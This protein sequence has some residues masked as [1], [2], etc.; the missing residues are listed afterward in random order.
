[1]KAKVLRFTEARK[2]SKVEAGP[3]LPSRPSAA[4]FVFLLF[5]AVPLSAAEL[6][7]VEVIAPTTNTVWAGQRVTFAVELLVQGQFAGSPHFDVPDVPGAIILKPSERP[8]LGTREIEGE[9]YTSQRH[10]FDLFVQRAGAC[11]VPPFTV[12]FAS[13]ERFGLPVVE[14][15]LRTR[16]FKVEAKAPPGASP[17]EIIVSTTELTATESWTPKPVGA[18]VGD[19]FTRRISMKAGGV[20]GMLLPALEHQRVEGFAVYPK[21]PEVRDRTE[22]GELTGERVESVTYVCEHA[23]TFE[24]PELAL[25][26]WNP[27]ES[28]WKERTFPAVAIEVAENPALAAAASLASEPRPLRSM[29]VW[30][31]WL[32]AVVTVSLI[33][34]W[35]VG[36]R[37]LR[38]WRNWRETRAAS[39]PAQFARLLQACGRGDAPATYRQLTVWL[40][41]FGRATSDLSNR[42]PGDAGPPLVEQCLRLQ[43]RLAGMNPR[44]DGRALT[45]ELKTL[46]Q[47]W[48][49]EKSG[50]ASAGLLPLNPS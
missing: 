17:G 30:L 28:V 32:A 16:L 4:T 2:G 5:L 42:R 22:R 39:E 20:P 34:L 23:G 47:Q 29:G 7:R 12:R 18:K 40:A 25:R 1:M 36:P 13:R 49:I 9:S 43:Q 37:L 27:K 14:H 35:I 50:A 48:R 3:S 6:A 24:I 11:S 19:A 33:V 15:E 38:W 46:R 10:D 41:R 26:W 45:A 21:P 8:L 31:R 44:W